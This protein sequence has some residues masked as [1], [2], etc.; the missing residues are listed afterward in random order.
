MAV[1]G[2]GLLSKTRSYK[3]GPQCSKS[4]KFCQFHNDYGHTTEE[5]RH[6]K[7]E[8]EWLIQNGY[9][10][11]Y[12][13][14][15]KTRG[16]GPYQKYEIDR[17]KN[18][19]NPSP[20]SLVKDMPR[21]SMTGK[22]KAREVMDVEPANDA[23]LIQ[24]GQEERRR[25]RTQDNYA[26]VITALLANYEIERVLIDSGSSVDILFEE[27]YDQMQLGDVPLEAVDTS[28][29]CFAGEVVH[30]RGTISLPLTLG[31]YFYERHAYSNS[32]WWIF[33]QHTTL[34]WD[35]QRLM[36]FEQSYPCIT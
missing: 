11:E 6:L 12:V 29:Y 7:N 14:W 16:T 13:C 25:P 8:I 2:K 22:T 23:P 19:K 3:D 26:L 18:V 24:F 5:S 21:S 15:E 4:D 34:S 17:D 27:A 32:W 10:Q 35:D 9:L 31:T 30:P 1:E 28:L 36:L 33:R 20:E